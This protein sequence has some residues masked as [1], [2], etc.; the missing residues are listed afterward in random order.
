VSGLLDQNQ[1]EEGVEG[2]QGDDNDKK[3]RDHQGDGENDGTMT[4]MTTTNDE[5]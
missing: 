1:Q 5:K 3:E 4:S 2:D